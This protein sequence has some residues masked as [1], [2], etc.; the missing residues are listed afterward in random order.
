VGASAYK[1]W[2]GTQGS[3]LCHLPFEVSSKG[4]LLSFLVSGAPTQELAGQMA[5]KEEEHIIC[6]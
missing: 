4:K 1:S 5:L 3:K 6:L 2:K